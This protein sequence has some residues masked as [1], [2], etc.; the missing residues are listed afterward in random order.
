[1]QDISQRREASLQYY[2][3]QYDS[4]YPQG[5]TPSLASS[6]VPRLDGHQDIDGEDEI[7]SAVACADKDKDEVDLVQKCFTHTNIAPPAD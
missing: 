3:E 4:A 2:R 6:S 5:P 7:D 1:M